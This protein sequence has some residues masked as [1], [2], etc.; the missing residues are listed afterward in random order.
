MYQVLLVDDERFILDGMCDLIDWGE[1]GLEIAGMVRGGKQALQ[2]LDST[3]VDILITDIS[4]PRMNGLELIRIARQKHADLKVIILSGYNEFEHL[5]E[6]MR[7]GIEN[8]LLKPVNVSELHQT[9]ANVLNKL[10]APIIPYSYKHDIH[11]IRNNTLHRW[12]T[13]QIAASEWEERSKLLQLGDVQSYRLAAIL[14]SEQAEE[15]TVEQWKQ[16]LDGDNPIVYRDPEGDISFIYHGHLEDVVMQEAEAHLLQLANQLEAAGASSAR[17]SMG[18]VEMVQENDHYSYNDARKVLNYFLLFPDAKLMKYG[19]VHVSEVLNHPESSLR[20]ETYNNLLHARSTVELASAIQSDFAVLRQQEG[21]TPQQLFRMAAEV[22]IRLKLAVEEVRPVNSE[23][24]QQITSSL[25]A[26]HHPVEWQEL[27]DIIEQIVQ[28]ATD[29]LHSH[30]LSPVVRQ[31]LKLVISS[32]ADN[33]TLKKLGDQFRIHPVYLGQLFR[34]ET[35]ENFAGYLNRYRIEEAKKLLQES[36]LKV[37]EVA[38]QVGYCETVYF[39]R[40][41]RKYVGV[42]PMEFKALV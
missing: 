36:N 2:F 39:N 37:S 31:L 6:G 16:L 33:W 22:I 7:L 19:D 17:I 42:S 32:Y 14:Q 38:Q 15:R 24:E 1:L 8:Y 30:D 27:M 41:F 34:K 25:E 18:R 20:W 28:I 35:G 12:M 11:I 29:A 40:Q 5:K 23:M 3:K 13:G 26:L 9:L 21:I 4:M 10:E